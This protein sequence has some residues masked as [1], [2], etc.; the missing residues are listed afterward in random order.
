MAVAVAVARVVVLADVLGVAA[1]GE[2]A[3]AKT[4]RIKA[5]INV[6]CC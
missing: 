5:S 4:R 6:S 1:V 2:D 3:D